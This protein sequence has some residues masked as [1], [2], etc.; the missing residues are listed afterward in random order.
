[1]WLRHPRKDQNSTISQAR[2]KAKDLRRPL[3]MSLRNKPSSRFAIYFAYSLDDFDINM[4][5]KKKLRSR[6]VREE[7]GKVGE[8]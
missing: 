4:W 1:M 5:K 2:R 6:S 8:Q 7:T 3:R